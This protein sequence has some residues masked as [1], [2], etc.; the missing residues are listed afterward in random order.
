MTMIIVAPLERVFTIWVNYKE[1]LH[2][3]TRV[4]EVWKP[5][6][7]PLTLDRRRASGRRVHLEYYHP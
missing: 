1:F 2:Y 6:K 4:P 5:V 3:M 7:G